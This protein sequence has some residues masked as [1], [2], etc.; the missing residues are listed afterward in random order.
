MLGHMGAYKSRS[1]QH[2]SRTIERLLEIALQGA[3]WRP[4]LESSAQYTIKQRKHLNLWNIRL[5]KG[6]LVDP[7]HNIS[8]ISTCQSEQTFEK[9]S[10]AYNGIN[11]LIE[12]HTMIFR[13]LPDINSCTLLLS[14]LTMA[15][16][17]GA[18]IVP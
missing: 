4:I 11:V 8:K 15:E 16:I 9:P 14:T 13:G 6:I 10:V 3:L 5:K 17:T 7:C 2:Y 12:H 1:L 18:T